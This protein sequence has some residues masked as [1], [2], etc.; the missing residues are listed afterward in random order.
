MQR[1]HSRKG[2]VALLLMIAGCSSPAERQITQTTQQQINDAL[3]RAPHGQVELALSYCDAD[4][5]APKRSQVVDLMR[6]AVF[7][8]TPLTPYQVV[9]T[10]L[11]SSTGDL[12]VSLR[13]KWIEHK[14]TPS[15]LTDVYVLKDNTVTFK[16]GGAS[17]PVN[18]Q[19][20]WPDTCLT[21]TATKRPTVGATKSVES[22]SQAVSVQ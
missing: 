17:E 22:I 7:A 11:Q 14:N 13:S 21:L 2:L 18:F 6:P 9:V 20:G 12:V 16:Q 19:V 1:K 4:P 3:K 10:S 5:Q 15:G 8:S